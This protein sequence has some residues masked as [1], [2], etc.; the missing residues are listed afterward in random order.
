[1]TCNALELNPLCHR[2]SVKRG[3]ANITAST[4]KMPESNALS[5]RLTVMFM[6]IYI[7]IST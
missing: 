3:G 7:E 4:K 5:I 1:M 2:V 6:C